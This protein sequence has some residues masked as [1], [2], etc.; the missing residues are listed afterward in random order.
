LSHLCTSFLAFQTNIR[1][2]NNHFIG[3]KKCKQSA[4][5]VKKSAN[6]VRKTFNLSALKV[7]TKCEKSP[8]K[9]QNKF[10]LSA[11]KVQANDEKKLKYFFFKI[12][13]HKMIT[14]FLNDSTQ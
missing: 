4:E 13:N 3:G 10:T 5:K 6:K 14:H 9:V 8:L 11:L 2:E 1:G 7:Q 12:Y